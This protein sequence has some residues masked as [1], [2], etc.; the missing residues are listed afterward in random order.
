[1]PDLDS[2]WRRRNRVLYT[3]IDDDDDDAD[4]QSIGMLRLTYQKGLQS[5]SKRNVFMSFPA[6]SRTRWHVSMHS[7]PRV[8]LARLDYIKGYSW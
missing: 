6:V 4:S 3:G 2:F 8:N 1:M 7:N 5:I